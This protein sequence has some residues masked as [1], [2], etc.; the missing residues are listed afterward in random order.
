MSEKKILELTLKN[1]N[2]VG[3]PGADGAARGP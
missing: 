2:F 3:N 1:I